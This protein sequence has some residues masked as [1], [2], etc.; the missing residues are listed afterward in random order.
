MN[1]GNIMKNIFRTIVFKLR[2]WYSVFLKK[3]KIKDDDF[4]YEQEEG[5]DKC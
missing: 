5:D 4:I 1:S 3:D 2:M